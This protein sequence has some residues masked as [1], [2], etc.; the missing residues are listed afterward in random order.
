[1]SDEDGV[2]R[3]DGITDEDGMSGMAH[4]NGTIGE[5]YLENIYYTESSWI[6]L[7]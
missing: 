4:G 7:E 2:V 5:I 3:D 6:G 1:M